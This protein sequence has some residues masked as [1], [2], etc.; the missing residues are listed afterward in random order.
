MIKNDIR[1]YEEEL[2]KI[3]SLICVI[4]EHDITFPLNLVSCI[5][6]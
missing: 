4:S 3:L 2:K 1:N 5:G 6:K